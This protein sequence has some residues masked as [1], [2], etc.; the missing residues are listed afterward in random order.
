MLTV[1]AYAAPSA[2]EPLVPTTIERRDVGAHDV[3]I[4]IAY[5]G[6]CH[7]DIHTV[8]GEWGP[9]QYP[10]TVG[11]E[12]VGVVA[13]VGSEVT[14]HKVG[15]RVGVGC[16]VNS[17]RECENCLAGEEQYC[18]KGNTGTYAS[19]D[20]D[21]TVTQGG[22]ST[23]VV[24]VEDFVLRVPES[25]PYEA[26]AP[27]LCAGITTYSPLSHWEAGPGK[28]VAVVGLGGLGH[29]AVKF[30]HAMGAEVTVL[31]QS[32]SKKEDGLRLGADHYY[33][34]KDE[35][36]FSTL[37]NHFDIIINTVSAPLDLDAY[38]GLLRRNGTMVNVGAPAEALPLHVFTLF[39]ARRSFAGSGIGGIRETQ[40]MLDF[41]AE[42]GIASEVEVVSASQINEA[43]ERVLA[44]DVRYRFVIDIATLTK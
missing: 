34:T 32:L 22:Y 7:S 6:I 14:K 30:A 37:A 28:R 1:N 41:C 39:G 43:Y 10:L 33:A 29:M 9:V 19:V 21:G 11:H 36:T 27:L 17:C 18:L 2:T 26:A 24:V 4:E 40:E 25:I 23:H 12:I 13:E 31:S 42:K 5:S 20:R 16:M 38:L 3:L 15:D 44:S 8:R 35:E